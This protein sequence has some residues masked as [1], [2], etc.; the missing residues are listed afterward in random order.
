ME[1][2]E[3][4]NLF[5]ISGPSG[6]GKS[7]VISKVMAI[8]DDVCFSISVTTRAPRQGEVEGQDYFFVSQ[9]EFDEMISGGLLLE[10]AEY[11][12]NR[13]GT[14]SEYVLKKRDAGLSVI[15]DIEV[16]GAAAVKEKMPGAVMV[17]ILPP[18]A[19]ELEC[20]LRSRNTDSEEKVQERLMQAKRECEKAHSYDYIV[21]NDDPDIAAKELDSIIT[22]EKC[23]TAERLNYIKEVLK[24]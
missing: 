22:A 12:G 10:H 17:F 9:V 23:R 20:R 21:V 14:P 1:H 8:R 24:S 2:F 4:G 11:V 13:Y 7:T 3:K 5:L 15:L 6:V 16:Q 19:K 18:G